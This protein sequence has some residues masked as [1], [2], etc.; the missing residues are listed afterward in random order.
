[1]FFDGDDQPHSPRLAFWCATLVTAGAQQLHSSPPL[2]AMMWWCNMDGGSRHSGH[3]E[4][5]GPLLALMGGLA[6]LVQELA[7]SGLALCPLRLDVAL[8]DSGCALLSLWLQEQ[9]PCCYNGGLLLPF[10]SAWARRQN[11]K[12]Q[13]ASL[14]PSIK[15]RAR[16]KQTEAVAPGQ[17]NGFLNDSVAGLFIKS[18]GKPHN[19]KMIGSL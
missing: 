11:N 9:K 19:H 12:V 1:M 14:H 7:R 13:S 18:P 8:S 6:K 4:P 2:S 16:P 15:E 5:P 3:G 10:A 17:A